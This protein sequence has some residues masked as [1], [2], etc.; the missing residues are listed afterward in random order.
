MGRIVFGTSLQ[1]SEKVFI[2]LANKVLPPFFAAL[3]LSS[4]LAAQIST[5]DSQLLVT[6]S[7]IANDVY[8]GFIKKDALRKQTMWMARIAIIA[9]TIVGA[10]LALNP[11]ESIFLLIPHA[12]S[13]VGA[14]FGPLVLFSL[15]WKRTTLRGTLSGMISGG[16]TVL[17][18]TIWLSKL[19][20]LFEVYEMIPAFIVSSLFIV[21]VS[22]IDC[23]PSEDILSEFNLAKTRYKQVH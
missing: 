10:L 7:A 9:I 20:G 1:D 22:L 6:S 5:S 3:A 4:I 2:H 21:F 14:A 8:K 12:W 13:G 17:I 15:F 19:G 18:W 11:R 23:R 16:L